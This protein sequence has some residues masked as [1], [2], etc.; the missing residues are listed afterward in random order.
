MSGGFFIARN[1]YHAYNRYMPY[2]KMSG[3]ESSLFEVAL[4]RIR[5]A[6]NTGVKD[7]R[8]EDDQNAREAVATLHDLQQSLGLHMKG[9]ETP[10]KSRD[11]VRFAMIEI[12]AGYDSKVKY[13]E[14]RDLLAD[15]YEIAINEGRSDEICEILKAGLDLLEKKLSGMSR[16]EVFSKKFT[17]IERDIDALGRFSEI[18]KSNSSSGM[19]V[20]SSVRT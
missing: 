18:P 15:E 16:K 4:N 3:N 1:L 10:E 6:K 17:A 2:E 14:A 11:A 8:D 13:E 5:D 12:G 9:T 20:S 19:S 7:T